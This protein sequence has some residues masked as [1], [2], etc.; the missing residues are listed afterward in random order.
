MHFA[1]AQ[2]ATTAAKWTKYGEIG[3]IALNC[4]GALSATYC[5]Q[6]PKLHL[7]QIT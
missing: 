1:L 4:I 5:A 7:T 6:S 3:W 2:K